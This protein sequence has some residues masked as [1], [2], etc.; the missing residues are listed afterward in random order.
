MQPWID[1]ITALLDPAS[2]MGLSAFQVMLIL[3]LGTYVSE[4]LACITAGLMAANAQLNLGL[5]IVACAIGIWTSDMLLYAVGRGF[6]S[7]LLHGSWTERWALSSKLAIG[8]KL[9]AENS[10]HFLIASR[11]LPGSRLPG[12]LAAGAL[13]YPF[14][15]FMFI[16]ALAVAVWTPLL[17]LLSLSFGKLLLPWLHDWR[18]WLIV[19]AAWLSLSLLGKFVSRL[20]S[21]R[22]RR[23]LVSRWIRLTHWEFWPSWAFYMPVA[24]WILWLSLRHR[25]LTLVALCNPGI[26]LSGLAMESKSEILDSLGKNNPH[27]SKIATWKAVPANTPHLRFAELSKFMEAEGLDYPIVLKPDVGERGQGVA[28]IRSA[29]AAQ[30][31]LTDCRGLVI[32]QRYIGG[33]EFGVFYSRQPGADKG[34]IISLAQ[35][36]PF[37]LY[38]DGVHTLEEL[39][40]A[41]PRAVAMAAYFAKKFAADYT[42][43]PALGQEIKLAEIGTHCRGAIFTDA[44]HHITESLRASV[45]ELTKPFH[46]FH[47]G[48]YDLRVPCLEDLKQGQNL[49]VLELN[50]MTAEPVHIYDPSYSIFKAWQDACKGWTQAFTA[51]AILRSAGHPVPTLKAILAALREHRNH[52]WFEADTLHTPQNN[53]TPP[54]A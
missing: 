52:A 15:K 24:F 2:L 14:R 50:G 32:A 42:G 49:Q 13:R 28:I 21:W 3:A 18:V 39:V 31:Y 4:D 37:S 23:L 11:F 40:L 9:M 47:Y 22:G 51:G 38:G 25:S 5:G 45:D 27:A 46:D 44:R 35:K 7:G 41:H 29:S 10:T 16:L 30:R 36:H 34:H 19:P 26:R 48:R 8:E 20:F 12:Y 53:P 1:S 6:R 33:L 43:I 17:C 54:Q